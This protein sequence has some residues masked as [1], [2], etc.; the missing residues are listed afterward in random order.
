MYSQC[1]F[2]RYIVSN[3]QNG[4]TYVF[5]VRGTDDVGNQGNPV[6]Y[7]WKVGEER[8]LFNK[9]TCTFPNNYEIESSQILIE[10]S[11]LINFSSLVV[12]FLAYGIFTSF[13]ISLGPGPFKLRRR[14]LKTHLGMI[15]QLTV[16]GLPSTLIRYEN[17]A[18]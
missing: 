3:L 10:G 1:N 8:L 6:T 16:T 2:N 18:F 7:T 5:G 17:G 13:V 12:K 11:F 14:N 15:T 9:R 4:K